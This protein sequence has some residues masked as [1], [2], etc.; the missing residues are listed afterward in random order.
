[1]LVSGLVK[2]EWGMFLSNFLLFSIMCVKYVIA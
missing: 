1:M 2:W